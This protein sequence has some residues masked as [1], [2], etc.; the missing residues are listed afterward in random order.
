[1]VEDRQ[2]A[3]RG[4]SRL[5]LLAVVVGCSLIGDPVQRAY[6]TWEFTARW[7][8]WALLGLATFNLL[9]TAMSP[10]SLIAPL[11]L[12][13]VSAAALLS[14][15]DISTGMIIDFGLPA[16]LAVGG[17]LLIGTAV[18]DQ[19]SNHWSRTL[20]TG[21]IVI[22]ADAAGTLTLRSVLG[23]LRADLTR[24]SAGSP[25]TVNITAVA[26][27][28]RVDIPRNRWVEVNASGALLTRITE[29]GPAP[30]EL[31]DPSTGFVIHVLGVCG[32]VGIARV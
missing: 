12:A 30:D 13:T 6:S 16:V 7:W 14:A 27:H 18:P 23:E 2:R 19:P 24:K 17:S 28:V 22:P 20:T 26:G 15:G 9:R 1:M 32:S 10:A 3:S 8:P 21:R 25:T 31:P 29:T 11:V 5:G 4:R